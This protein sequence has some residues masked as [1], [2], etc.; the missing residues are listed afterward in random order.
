MVYEPAQ[1]PK[2]ADTAARKLGLIRDSVAWDEAISGALWRLTADYIRG[3]LTSNAR[4]HLS[5]RAG[6]IEGL[7]DWLGRDG[8]HVHTSL[9]ELL[10]DGQHT[11]GDLLAATPC[12]PLDEALAR[13]LVEQLGLNR[14]GR[15]ALARAC[16]WGNT[17][18][19]Q[20]LGVTQARISQINTKVADRL[21]KPPSDGLVKSA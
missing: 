17:E 9:D 12:D 7:R 16:G 15:I 2:V 13:E 11:R 14:H 8:R 19:A 4:V 20:A 10:P 3:A 18:I 21:R 6:A 1:F 5:A